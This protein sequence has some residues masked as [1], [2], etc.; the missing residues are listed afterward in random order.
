MRLGRSGGYR[1]GG[2]RKRLDDDD[3]A[4]K[5]NA[6][7]AR[8]TVRR[9]LR[10]ARPQLRLV[11]WGLAFLLLSAL[12]GLVLPAL[13]GR[14]IDSITGNRE[15]AARRLRESC[16][17][18]L[19]V[20][21]LRGLFNFGSTMMFGVAGERVVRHIRGKLFHSLLHQ[22]VAFFDSTMTG[23]RGSRRRPR[24]RLSSSRPRRTH[25]LAR[26]SSSIAC[27]RTARACPTH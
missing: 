19:V 22:D 18:L 26:R 3:A 6:G 17:L 13:F 25:A 5:F 20:A 7:V 16:V 10:E 4:V 2:G 15:A 8:V 27:R 12:C 1:S 14:I 21:V 9:M 24:A 11:V 23:V